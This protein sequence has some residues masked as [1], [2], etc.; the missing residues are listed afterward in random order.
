M[1]IEKQSTLKNLITDEKRLRRRRVSETQ[2]LVRPGFQA[3]LRHLIADEK[4]LLRE[5]GASDI[6]TAVNEAKESESSSVSSKE[7]EATQE[8]Q[9][10]EGVVR[11][12]DKGEQEDMMQLFQEAFGKVQQPLSYRP[13]SS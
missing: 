5:N 1:S 6:E 3:S 9:D 12:F 4:Q 10:V 7:V 2:I 8:H 11:E 13:P